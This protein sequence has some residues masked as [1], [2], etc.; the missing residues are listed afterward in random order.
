MNEILGAAEGDDEGT[1]VGAVEGLVVVVGEIDRVGL[2]DV[3]GY[4]SETLFEES[5]KLSIPNK[6]DGRKQ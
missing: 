5:R 6:V 1:S 2:V 3:E 4:N